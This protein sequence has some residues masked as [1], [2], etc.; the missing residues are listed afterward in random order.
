MALYSDDSNGFTLS[1]NNGDDDVEYYEYITKRIWI[2]CPPITLVF[3]TT[4]NILSGKSL[5]YSTPLLS[6]YL[7]K[8][9]YSCYKLQWEF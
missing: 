3:G 9:V 4:G 2:I 8:A 1:P 6:R 7:S 5:F